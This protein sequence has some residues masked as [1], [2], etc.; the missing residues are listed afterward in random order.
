MWKND[1]S[2]KVV[3]VSQ[4]TQVLDILAAV[5]KSLD[6]AYLRLDGTVA[7]NKRGALVVTA[8]V[9]PDASR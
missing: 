1:P 6:V 7:Q 5:L 3:I 4:T 8:S 9:G 2:D